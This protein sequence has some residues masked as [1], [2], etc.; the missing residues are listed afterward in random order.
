MVFLCGFAGAVA[1]NYAYYG[2]GT[3]PILLDDVVCNGTESSLFECDHNGFGIHNC[4]HSED[5]SVI[6]QGN[7]ISVQFILQLCMHSLYQA[8]LLV[9]AL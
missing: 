3:G 9:G 7:I 4:A 2:Q 5:A 1:R 8:K 6:C